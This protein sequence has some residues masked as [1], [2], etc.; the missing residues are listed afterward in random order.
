M[1][2]TQRRGDGERDVTPDWDETMEDGAP[3]PQGEHGEEAGK[4]SEAETGE[5]RE[6]KEPPAAEKADE[7]ADEPEAGH[8]REPPADHEP[9]D[10]A[11]AEAGGD[12]EEVFSAEDGRLVV[13]MLR[14]ARAR[15]S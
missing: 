8:D 14:Q 7:S 15:I 5:R 9:A 3:E 10:D 4:P 2:V 1:F 11:D 12:R 6:D 13:A